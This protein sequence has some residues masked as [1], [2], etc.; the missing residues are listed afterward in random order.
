MSES[1]DSNS[2]PAPE[3]GGKAVSGGGDPSNAPTPA[4]KD[5][6]AGEGYAVAGY[7]KTPGIGDPGV[8]GSKTNPVEEG[9]EPQ[10]AKPP[11]SQG[12]VPA[13]KGGLTPT[14]PE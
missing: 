6:E 11:H 2:R 8:P 10:P 13:L 3:H 14:E 7:Q 1:Q 9:R 4:A 12:Q 5:I